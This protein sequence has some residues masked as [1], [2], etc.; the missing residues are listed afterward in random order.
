MRRLL[1]IATILIAAGWGLYLLGGKTLSHLIASRLGGFV[2]KLGEGKISS[3]AEFIER[4]MFEGAWLATLLLLWAFVHLIVARSR[5]G[6]PLG[7]RWAWITHSLLALLCLNLWLWQADRTVF[8]W[9]LMWDGQQTQNLAR[10][11]IKLI[12]TAEDRFKPRAVLMGSSQTRAQIDEELLNSLLGNKLRTTE[13]HYPGSKAYDHLLLQPILS[14][15]RADYVIVYLSEA[16]FHS[17][18]ASEAVPNFFRFRDL[19]DLIQRGGT[20][21]VPAGGIGYGLLGQVLPIFHLREVLAQRLLGPAMVQIKQQQYNVALKT[22]LVERG[23]DLAKIYKP[24]E[25]SRFHQRALEDFLARCRDSNQRVLLLA[26]QLNPI[27]SRRIEP[28]TRREMVELLHSLAAR[29]P[30]VTVVE[31]LPEQ[32][33]SDY[34]DMTHVTKPA[35]DRFTR[36]LASWLE[37]NALADAAKRR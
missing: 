32:A 36:F 29:F 18:S 26:G 33:E 1:S 6:R 11:R 19:P 12:L 31:N 30:N 7:N 9:G 5:L 13:M 17:G 4:R 20:R 8:F 35:Q 27:M 24:N 16:D 23:A 22:N 3:P 2:M 37:Q 15:A 14:P 28:E 34:A 21:F 10:F 25:E